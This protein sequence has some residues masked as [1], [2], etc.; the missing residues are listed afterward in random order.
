MVILA[1]LCLVQVGRADGLPVEMTQDSSNGASNGVTAEPVVKLDV[2]VSEAAQIAD[3]CK[4]QSTLFAPS[5]TT[6]P[7]FM[8]DPSSGFVVSS[9]KA[10]E[11]HQVEKNV[12]SKTSTACIAI[13]Q[14]AKS[15]GM[16]LAV[17]VHGSRQDIY[18]GDF[19]DSGDPS[20]VFSVSGSLVSAKLEQASRSKG[21]TYFTVVAWDQAA[22]TLQIS[23]GPKR[24]PVFKATYICNN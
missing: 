19:L 1:V 24:K 13:A 8:L 6:L 2:H 9:I 4:H 17:D 16:T 12:V 18:S 14:N 10:T 20:V 23:Y 22:K 21:L 3:M 5:S 7:Q 15:K 11:C